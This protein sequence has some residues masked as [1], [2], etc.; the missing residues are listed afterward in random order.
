[1]YACVF[2]AIII[3]TNKDDVQFGRMLDKIV[4]Y[5]PLGLFMLFVFL[6]VLSKINIDLSTPFQIN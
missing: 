1:M 3:I 6:T 2:I 5:D 4:S